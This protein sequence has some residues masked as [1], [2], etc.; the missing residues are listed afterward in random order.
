MEKPQVW[1]YYTTEGHW[2]LVNSL[3]YKPFRQ[4]AV[5]AGHIYEFVC[6]MMET[7]TPITWINLSPMSVQDFKERVA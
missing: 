4:G 2:A 3:H 5:P 7:L 6:T 1:F